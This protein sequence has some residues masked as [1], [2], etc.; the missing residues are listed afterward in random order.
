LFASPIPTAVFPTSLD[1]NIELSEWHSVEYPANFFVA[2]KYHKTFALAEN[3]R[4][5]EGSH[6]P[7][8][9]IETLSRQE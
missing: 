1:N 8:T 7:E 6:I 9:A 5:G 4:K 2:T 3:K